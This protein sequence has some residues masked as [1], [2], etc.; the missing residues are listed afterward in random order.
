MSMRERRASHV[1]PRQ[2]S[3]D[4]LRSQT[5]RAAAPSKEALHRYQPVR[6]KGKIP[7]PIGIAL[8]GVCL[9]FGFL[10]LSIGFGLLS[11]VAGQ[12]G[13]AINGALSKV[14]S[15]APATMGPSGV[16]LDTP[17]FDQPPNQGFTNE[18]QVAL[19]GSVPGGAA[20]KSGYLVRVFTVATNG[21]KSPVADV[22]VGLVTHFQTPALNLAE[23]PNAFVA[24]LVS[25][26]GEGSSSPPVVYTLDTKAPAIKIGSPANNS[27]Q[28][29]TSASVH[30]TGTTDASATVTIRNTKAPGGSLSS[31]VVGGDGKF[32]L[33]VALVAGSNPIQVTSTDLAGNT[34]PANLT[35]KRDFGHLAVH[36]SVA[37]AK[38][39]P[40]KPTPIT[41]TAHAT[42]ANGGPLANASVTFTLTIQGL[43]PITPN[44]MKTDATGTATWTT[45]I[46]NATPGGSGRATVQVTSST[47]D[48]ITDS[49]PVT[50][51]AS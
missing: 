17:V 49:A 39:S 1:R 23:G 9:V 36:L 32:D 44:S 41:L 33:T 7:I 25:P 38:I 16:A 20:G 26:S 14:S 12:L 28:A 40:S 51:A 30:V 46:S 21:A 19:T 8:V 43:G 48:S 10:T 3:S 5:I 34:T 29:A 35:L 45:T 50:T 18:K 4:R 15:Q 31:Q 22:P 47:G 6:T 13:G 11:G 27:T 24:V 2:P 42:S 37:P